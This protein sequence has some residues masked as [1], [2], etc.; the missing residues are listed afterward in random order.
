MTGYIA[1]FGIARLT[2]ANDIESVTSAHLLKGSIGY[3]APEYGLGENVSTK[4]YVYSYG[5]VLL[6]ILTRKKPTNNMFVEGLNLPRW[7]TINF[8]NKVEE[9][10]DNNLL[11]KVG[12]DTNELP[13]KA[14]LITEP[15]SI[16]LSCTQESPQKRPNMIDIMSGLE[17]IRE[18][19]Q[20]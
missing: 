9:V 19:W 20:S 3:I 13:M 14:H 7:I 12:G 4:G 1:D 11:R 2:F 18:I 8:P 6:E 5:I 17:R 15:L 16:G 10:I